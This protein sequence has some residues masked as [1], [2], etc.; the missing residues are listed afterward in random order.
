MKTTLIWI[1]LLLALAGTV[2]FLASQMT[3][4]KNPFKKEVVEQVATTTP[5]LT[6]DTATVY[7]CSNGGV[8][9]AAFKTGDTSVIEVSIPDTNPVIMNQAESASGARYTNESGLVFWE[10]GGV[11]MIEKS[12]EVIYTDC[13][14]GTM[15]DAS[16]VSSSTSPFT[17]TQWVWTE[18]SF[19]TASSVE[20]NEPEDFIVTFAE[21]NRFSANTDCNNVGGS[22]V[23]GTDGAIAFTD[24]VS[25]LMACEGDV[26]ESAFVSQLGQVVSYRID[27]TNLVLSMKSDGDNG[28]MQFTKK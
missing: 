18:T 15:P 24:M 28:E 2:L 19:A 10:K 3:D 27:G 22:Y 1:V 13:K 20:P 7:T 4:I 21:N 17:D 5:P 6:F 25:T 14:A 12:G 23:G 11:V 16:L 9:A 26:K 8:V